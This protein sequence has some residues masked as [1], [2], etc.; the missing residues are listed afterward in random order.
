[1][2]RII[3]QSARKTL[4]FVVFEF[5]IPWVFETNIKNWRNILIRYSHVVPLFE[6][7]SLVALPTSVVSLCQ[8]E[9]Y[10]NPPPCEVQ[11]S[12]YLVP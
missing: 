9:L 1:M 11:V 5:Y 7:S 4:F 3:D 12:F 8:L 10:C 6:A 2:Y